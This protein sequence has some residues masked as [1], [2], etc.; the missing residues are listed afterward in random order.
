M[1]IHLRADEASGQH[2]RFTVFMNGANC[3]QLCMREDEAVHFHEMV[4]RSEYKLPEDEYFSS[5]RWIKKDDGKEGT[6][7]IEE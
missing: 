4:T 1:K 3:G 2:T 5:G 7:E 6:I